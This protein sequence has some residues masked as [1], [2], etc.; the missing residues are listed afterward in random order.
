MKG[1]MLG[2]AVMLSCMVAVSGFAGPIASGFQP[3]CLAQRGQLVGGVCRM[4]LAGAA[5]SP[6]AG[7]TLRMPKMT[8]AD[9]PVTGDVET[10]GGFRYFGKEAQGKKNFRVVLMAGFET[11]NRELY[12]RAADRA[13]GQCDGLE[14]FVFTDADIDQNPEALASALDGADVF[15]GSLIFDFNQVPTVVFAVSM[16]SSRTRRHEMPRTSI[17]SLS[18]LSNN[19]DVDS[20]ILARNV[21][22][23]NFPRPKSFH[24]ALQP[25]E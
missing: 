7:A 3:S 21:S 18:P 11:F 1:A 22:D 19:P 12:K 16:H 5:V 15:F 8:L 13:V 24:S 23:V 25:D 20:A 10:D 17:L 4:P 6:R 9:G 2:T 14:I